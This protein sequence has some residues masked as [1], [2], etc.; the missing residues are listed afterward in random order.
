MSSP[1]PLPPLHPEQER[2]YATVDHVLGI[3][4]G[5][6]PA[7]V[8]FI[9]FRE[10]GPF[11]RRHVVTEWNWQLTVLIV[12]VV[13]GIVAAAGWAS[14]FASAVHSESSTV[15]TLPAGF[16]VFFIGYAVIGITSIVRVIFGIIAA[17]AANRGR[18]YVFPLA[19]RFAKA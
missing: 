10:R 19:F 16:I 6:I 3:F 7:I 13:G 4:F 2:Q 5:F 1:Q 11:I 17:V 15:H 14:A 12:Q 18:E 8:F 9:L